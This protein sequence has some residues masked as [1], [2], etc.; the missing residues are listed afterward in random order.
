MKDIDSPTVT[1]SSNFS[2]CLGHLPFSEMTVSSSNLL[3]NE[4]T[5]ILQTWSTNMCV[6][7]F[8]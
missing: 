6:Q 5:W 3:E 8:L 4:V 1:T 7:G 2:S